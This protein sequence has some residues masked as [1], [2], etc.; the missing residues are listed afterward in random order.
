MRR[1][2]RNPM[3]WIDQAAAS[4]AAAFRF[5][6]QPSRPMTPR[7]VPKSGKAALLDPYQL[8]VCRYRRALLPQLSSCEP[9]PV[10][11]NDWVAHLCRR[12]AEEHGIPDRRFRIDHSSLAPKPQ[13]PANEVDRSVLLRSSNKGR[14][15]VRPF[16]VTRSRHLVRDKMRSFPRQ[17]VMVPRVKG[18]LARLLIGLIAVRFGAAAFWQRRQPSPVGAAPR[19]AGRAA[20]QNSDQVR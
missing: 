1:S 14:T 2:L 3:R 10:I 6:R 16:I 11:A 12:R 15:F 8:M 13:R 5:L 4:A 19:P 9:I 17:S 20:S 7:P 18:D